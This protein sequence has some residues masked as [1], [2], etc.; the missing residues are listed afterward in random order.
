M[1]PVRIMKKRHRTPMTREEANTIATD[2]MSNPESL[3]NARVGSHVSNGTLKWSV[4]ITGGPE[5]AITQTWVF[6]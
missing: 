2:L 6:L 4:H 1:N 3:R 5:G